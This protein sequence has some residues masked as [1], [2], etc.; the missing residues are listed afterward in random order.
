[1]SAVFDP[2]FRRRLEVLRQVVARALAGRGG[3]GRSPLLERGGRVEFGGHRAYASGDDVRTIDWNACAR[4]GTFVVK[5][6]E[7]PREAQLLL[8]LDRSPSMD[9]FGKRETMLR[10]AAALGWLGL[11]A[12]ARVAAA[13]AAAASAWIAAP[14]RL[15]E[16]LDV[17]EKLPPQPAAD[18]PGAVGRAP[19]GGTGRK[20][21]VLLSDFYEGE[22]LA[23]ALALA[24]R[25]GAT[26]VCAQVVAHDELRPPAHATLEVRDAESGE[27]L[28]LG[29]DAAARA[30]FHEAA[31]AFLADRAA[32]A[33]RHGARFVRV[34]PGDDLVSSVTQ[35]LLGVER[36]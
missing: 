36:P 17:L 30:R 6:F 33:A 26:V 22:A 20:T 35:V 27:T 34:A 14:E 28:S 25:R 3:A 16:L 9:H 8:L 1:M 7:A 5:E 21:L 13:T 32:L 10:L 2:E 11:L 12:G 15:Q 19:P 31:A 4:L 18:L 29:L 24:S 23:R